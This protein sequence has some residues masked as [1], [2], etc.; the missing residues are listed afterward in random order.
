MV[1]LLQL[2]EDKMFFGIHSIVSLI[3]AL[4]EEVTE[5][6]LRIFCRHKNSELKQIEYGGGYIKTC[7]KCGRI[8]YEH[9]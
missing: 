5:I 2:G 7:R 9:R 6:F 1:N 4:I 8:A 3:E